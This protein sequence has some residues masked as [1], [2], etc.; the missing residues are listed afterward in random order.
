MGIPCSHA[1][2]FRGQLCWLLNLHTEN[3]VC[4]TPFMIW[5]KKCWKAREPVLGMLEELAPLLGAV[6]GGQPPGGA[7][8]T[9]NHQQGVCFHS[10]PGAGGGAD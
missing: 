5:E 1:E 2:F 4:I 3:I 7:V 6:G 10:P 9:G 8:L